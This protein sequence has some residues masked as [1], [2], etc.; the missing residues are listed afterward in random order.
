MANTERLAVVRMIRKAKHVAQNIRYDT[1]FSR[2]V[3]I[4][5]E[6]I[7]IQLDK[8]EDDLILEEIESRVTALESASKKLA[9]V[10][11]KLKAENENLAALGEKI[12]IA[13][14]GLSTL[15]DIAAKGAALM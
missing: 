13:A 7:Y 14:K 15:V 1:S 10:A 9:S 4:E 6:D 5:V 2:E 3:R 12:E 11:S 8:L